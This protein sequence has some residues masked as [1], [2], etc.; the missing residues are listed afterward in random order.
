MHL[1]WITAS[2]PL[3][4][5][6]PEDRVK[7]RSMGSRVLKV[8]QGEVKEE[9][10]CWTPVSE[11][12]PGPSFH[13]DGH[14][15][16]LAGSPT[17]CE[18]DGCNVFGGPIARSLNLYD[19]LQLLIRWTRLH[20]GTALPDAEQWQVSEVDVTGNLVFDQ[21]SQ[22]LEA[23]GI[24]KHASTGRHKV[25]RT[26]HDT[27]YWNSGSRLIAATAYAKGDELRGTARKRAARKRRVYSAE[28]LALVGRLLR[29]ELHLRGQ[30]F[31]R[32]SWR[33]MSPK[34]LQEQWWKFF[35]EK[36]GDAAIKT[37]NDVLQKLL[38]VAPTR[39]QANAAYRLWTCIQS[40]G[41]EGA[42]ATFPAKATWQRHLK[43]LKA[44]GLG[45][46]DLRAGRVMPLRRNV[47][48]YQLA[49]DWTDLRRVS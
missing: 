42:R 41:F 15:L 14:R 39:A 25:D 29:L 4:R 36:L 40:D 24:L 16:R 49:T 38:E 23:L 6:T 5:L 21:A 11:N 33:D 18:G 27:C 2:L 22:V 7:L 31:A 30:F 37:P 45:D 43:H 10:A 13:V 34:L 1:D 19:C 20:L 48:S 26:Y 46:A 47:L 44:A 17:R 9:Y 12:H 32:N 28:E 35:M 3:D 8:H